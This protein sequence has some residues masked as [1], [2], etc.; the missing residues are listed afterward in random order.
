[1]LHLFQT[2]AQKERAHPL[3]HVS[4]CWP[5]ALPGVKRAIPSA[6]CSQ[7][8]G[9]AA[10]SWNCTK[11]PTQSCLSLVSPQP[12]LDIPSGLCS[13][14]RRKPWGQVSSP[15]GALGQSFCSGSLCESSPGKRSLKSET[16]QAQHR[17]QSLAAGSGPS[18]DFLPSSVFT[19][20]GLSSS[21]PDLR[22]SPTSPCTWDHRPLVFSFSCE[23]PPILL[24][25]G[26]PSWVTFCV[27]LPPPAKTT[28]KTRLEHADAPARGF[29][30]HLFPVKTPRSPCLC[31]VCVCR[32]LFRL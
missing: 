32:V 2:Q 18:L 15:R 24:L 6:P 17:W 31:P 20:L 28:R 5:L 1:M 8:L 23:S 27:P 22:C 26:R 14:D 21:T 3:C 16:A 25:S 10:A 19:S 7:H 12:G 13:R 11:Y 9:P 29:L 4:T 30:D